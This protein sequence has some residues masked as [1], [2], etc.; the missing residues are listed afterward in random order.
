MGR[1]YFYHDAAGPT[2][3]PVTPHIP[4]HRLFAALSRSRCTLP[5]LTTNSPPPQSLRRGRLPLDRRR[6]PPPRRSTARVGVPRLPR[7][8]SL[9]FR[10]LPRLPSPPFMTRQLA[11]GTMLMRGPFSAC[12]ST[13]PPL[14]T[15]DL[16]RGRAGL[17]LIEVSLN[18]FDF[19]R[20]TQRLTRDGSRATA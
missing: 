2:P 4:S 14:T 17:Y 20:V 3:P 10:R 16:P 1:L 8:A 15:E 19:A 12:A 11:R 9:R 13:P 18:G 7:P 6:R 5:P